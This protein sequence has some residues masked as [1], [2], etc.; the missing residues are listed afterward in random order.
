[1]KVIIDGVNFDSDNSEIVIELSRA[2]QDSIAVGGKVAAKTVPDC[3]TIWHFFR[4]DAQTPAGA[5]QAQ[6]PP[7]PAKDAAPNAVVGVDYERIEALIQERKELQSAIREGEMTTP[8]MDCRLLFVGKTG[9]MGEQI[10]TAILV[11]KS[12]RQDVQMLLAVILDR[13]RREVSRIDE[14]F[15]QLS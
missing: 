14:M 10:G 7:P 4:P 1:M 15:R 8:E 12:M 5:A 2:E 9:R 6:S 3:N 11:P 13:H